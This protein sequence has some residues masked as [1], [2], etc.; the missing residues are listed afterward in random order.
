MNPGAPRITICAVFVFF[1]ITLQ[2]Q[3][4]PA[5]RHQQAT[6]QIK[7]AAAELSA[8]CLS[9]A[10]SLDDWKQRRPQLRHQLL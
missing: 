7:R 8:R 4:G 2:A 9:D 10:S 5:L 1:S 6:N 3:E